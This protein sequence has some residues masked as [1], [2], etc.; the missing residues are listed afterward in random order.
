MTIDD[1]CA[2]LDAAGYAYTRDGN[3]LSAGGYLDLRSLTSERQRYQG[4]ET[5]LRTVDGHCMRLLGSRDVGGVTL[6]SAQYF[7]G[8]LDT[9]PRCYVAQNGDDY[10][11]GDS[12]EQ[13]LRDLRFKLDERDLDP[14]ELVAEIKARGVVRF[15]DYRLLTGAC[16]SGL[17]E[18]L[19]TLGKPD[20]EELP[21]P[22]ALEL[23]VGAYGSA[24]FRK[25]M[26]ETE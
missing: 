2:A 13:A 20:A 14:A 7:R 11:H 23:C 21:L 3:T 26:G 19:R 22:E 10:A 15:N 24:Q 4:Q 16:E 9:D 17:R 6:W 1:L 18:G 5:T 12:A 25:L 8:H